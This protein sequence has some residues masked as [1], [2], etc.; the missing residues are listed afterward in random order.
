[1]G[2]AIGI[3]AG[4]WVGDWSPASARYAIAQSAQAGFDLIE[5]PA[6]DPR[7]VDSAETVALLAEHGLDA[8][9]SL[10]LGRRDDINTTDAHAS[11]RGERR[12]LD[13]VAFAGDLGAS[14]IGGVLYSM[15]GKYD[16]APS[17]QARDNS[18]AVLGR[19]AEAAGKFGIT[20]GLEYVNRYESNLLNTAA[21][22]VQ[23]IHDLAASNVRLHLDTY[24]ANL[25]EQGQAAAVRDA[26]PHLVYIHAAENHRGALGTGNIDWPGL[27]RQLALSGYTGPI[28][29]ESFAGTIQPV[30]VATDIALWRN[31]WSDPAALARQAH[32]FIAAQL[33]AA[34]S[35]TE[36]TVTATADFATV[37]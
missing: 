13:A 32:G 27:F 8:V 7:T 30:H 12:L 34:R 15:M 3:H 26:G 28:T 2:N 4:V 10:A 33:A 35:A 23:F 18:L 17:E 29:F 21:Q 20:L 24:H 5:I 36:D 16:V 11:A 14:Y 1:M 22:T 25:E 9:V 6:V 31:L 19:V 37:P